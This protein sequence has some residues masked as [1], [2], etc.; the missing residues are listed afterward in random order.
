MNWEL[1]LHEKHF[2]KK[3][4]LLSLSFTVQSLNL[5]KCLDPWDIFFY[6]LVHKWYMNVT[7]IQK[8]M[9]T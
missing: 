8:N 1:N 7:E 3:N 9:K 4:L 5:R 6:F 2:N